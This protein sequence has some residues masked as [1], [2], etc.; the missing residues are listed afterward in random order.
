MK[1]QVDI[2]TEFITPVKH[3]KLIHSSY[4]EVL[5]L[6]RSRMSRVFIFPKI[7][8]HI[9]HLGQDRIAGFMQVPTCVPS[10]ES[11]IRGLSSLPK[12]LKKL[13]QHIESSR[14]N[15]SKWEN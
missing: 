3:A 5:G 6:R 14:A 10:L 1:Y 15:R 4:R 13:A 11:S 8:V 2:N 12:Q 9:L 7:G